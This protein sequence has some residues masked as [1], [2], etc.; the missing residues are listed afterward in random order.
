MT[1]AVEERSRPTLSR[2]V[3]VD[4]ALQL[5]LEQPTASLTLARLGTALGA[6][7]TAIYR[8]FRNRAELVAHLC[9]H[10]FGEAISELVPPD[11][12]RE[13]LS[14]IATQVRSSLLR[15]PSL[16][17]EAAARFTGGANERAGVE[18]IIDVFLRAGFPAADARVHAR[19]FGALLMA[20]ITSSAAALTGD[21]GDHDDDMTIAARLFGHDFPYSISEYEEDTFALILRT[22]VAGLEALLAGVAA[23]DGPHTTAGG[24]P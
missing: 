22:H 20:T 11:D 10:L 17:V 13:A 24:T 2:D 7:P 8:H 4:A 3:I 23:G 12:W 19:T 21:E 18:M 15:R 9:E 5:T 6:D 1:D 14:V 16:A